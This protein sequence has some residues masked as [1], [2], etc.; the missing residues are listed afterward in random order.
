[1]AG[2]DDVMGLRCAAGSIVGMSAAPSTRR[3]P[4]TAAGGSDPGARELPG[5]DLNLLRTFLVV[6]RSGSFTAAA[7]QLGL[8]QPTVTAQIRTLETHLGHELFERRPRGVEPTGAAHGLAARVAEPL[9]ALAGLDQQ[10]CGAGGRPAP[11][12][13]AAPSELLCT[14]LLPGVA[15]LVGE[16][17]Q[18][19][20]AQGGTEQ[21]LAELREGTH[22]LAITTRRPRGGGLVSY[23]LTDEEYLLVAAPSWAERLEV[24]ES[25]A[26]ALRSVP[27]VAD[28]EEMP[29]VRRYWRT[30]FGAQ[31]PIGPALTVPSLHAVVGAVARGAGYAVV[32]RSLCLEHLATGR[33]VQLD[34]PCDGPLNTLFLVE[35]AGA[36]ANPDIARVRDAL[37]ADAIDWAEPQPPILQ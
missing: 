11:V 12:H 26:S 29:M 34:C 24:S 27:L 21:L 20:I 6:Y 16:G 37:R 7:P 9:D 14:R 31:P 8:S 17:V 4:R 19:R 1:M 32:P 10:A 23:P 25:L 3:P 15:P 2:I 22:D 13:L 30:V 33:L 18:V 5:G 28:A 36:E 35:R